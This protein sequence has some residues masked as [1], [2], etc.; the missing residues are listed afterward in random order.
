MAKKVDPQNHSKWSLEELQQQ[1]NR[2]TNLLESSKKKLSEEELAYW[3]SV[4]APKSTLTSTLKLEIIQNNHPSSKRT[5]IMDLQSAKQFFWKAI[6]VQA[7]KEHFQFILNPNL[8]ML[9]PEFTAYFTFHPCQLDH[10]KG[11][12]LWGPIGS[13][14]SFLMRAFQLALKVGQIDQHRFKI[15]HVPYLYQK[16]IAN[17]SYDLEPYYQT[18]YC[19]D[20][21]GFHANAIKSWGNTLKPME[22]ILN[23]RYE[24]YI[25]NGLLT[26]ATSNFPLESTHSLKGLDQLL[27]LRIVSRMKQMM[28]FVLLEGEDFRG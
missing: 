25:K 15:T 10:Q 2:P 7:Q 18:N 9:L 23:H 26:H 12:Y 19:F 27:D 3:K 8:Q 5:P 16:I 14:K 22:M 17:P 6:Q 11:I 24:S 1:M 28:N 21:L 13:G 20:D 4:F